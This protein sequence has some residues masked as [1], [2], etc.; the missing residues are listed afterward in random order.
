MIGR[1]IWVWR[2]RYTFISKIEI[3]YFWL[4]LFLRSYNFRN[5]ANISCC[6]IHFALVFFALIWLCVIIFCVHNWFVPIMTEVSVHSPT[7]S[8]CH[9]LIL[10]VFCWLWSTNVCRQ[11]FVYCILVKS[12]IM[13]NTSSI[14]TSIIH[15]FLSLLESDSRCIT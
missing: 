13:R 1:L 8:H 11:Q 10:V 12:R 3:I 4:F 2:M 15:A 14:Y 7:D 5:V 9:C 6:Y